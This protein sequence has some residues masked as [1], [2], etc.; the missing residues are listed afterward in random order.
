MAMGEL[1]V[2]VVVVLFATGASA[3]AGTVRSVALRHKF[4]QLGEITGRSLEEVIRH[5]GNPSRRMPA[6]HGREL[7]VWRRMNFQ[8]VLRFT[9]GVCDGMDYNG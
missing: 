6:G 4:E 8:V 2:L 5:V 9:G 3:Y 1:A 7:L